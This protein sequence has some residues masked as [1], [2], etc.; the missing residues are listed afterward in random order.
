MDTRTEYYPA[1]SGMTE[2]QY[3]DVMDNEFHSYLVEGGFMLDEIVGEAA[4][5]LEELE[6]EAK[7]FITSGDPNK[8]LDMI[9]GFEEYLITDVV[10][11]TPSDIMKG[12]LRGRQGVLLMSDVWL[13]TNRV[14]DAL[15]REQEAMKAYLGGITR[16]PACMFDCD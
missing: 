7:V 12:H 14:R 13:M 10:F 11:I 1:G 9:H 2:I 4:N 3:W 5:M 6:P 16:E 15:Y 8:L